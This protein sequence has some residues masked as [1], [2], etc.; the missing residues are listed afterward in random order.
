[1]PE[2]DLAS[3][4]AYWDY[5]QTTTEE[6]LAQLPWQSSEASGYDFKVQLAP[7]ANEAGCNAMFVLHETRTLPS[8]PSKTMVEFMLNQTYAPGTPVLVHAISSHMIGTAV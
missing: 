4:P 6:I 5:L 3:S 1:M 8:F 2:K 7:E